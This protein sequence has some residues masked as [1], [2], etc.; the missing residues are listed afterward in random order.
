MSEN[1]L[2]WF[3][4][5]FEKIKSYDAQ[6]YRISSYD[7]VPKLYGEIE[8]KYDGGEQIIITNIY[9]KTYYFS[10]SKHDMKQLEFIFQQ[11][12]CGS[13][14]SYNILSRDE[15]G[16]IFCNIY[17][18]HHSA[19]EFI[20][21]KGTGFNSNPFDPTIRISDKHIDNLIFISRKILSN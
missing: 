7:H 15:E 4:S 1:N 16:R 9:Y 17:I 12:K 8:I 19:C 13:K 21:I 2:R 3:N 5:E 18:C 14:E 20:E 10:I 6:W 11:I